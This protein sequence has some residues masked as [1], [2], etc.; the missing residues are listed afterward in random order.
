MPSSNRQPPT[1]QPPTH[2]RGRSRQQQ[3]AHQVEELTHQAGEKN[4]RWFVLG[5]IIT[6]GGGWLFWRLLPPQ[7]QGRDVRVSGG[8]L[9]SV[10]GGGTPITPPQV[11]DLGGRPQPG[12]AHGETC[13]RRRR[14]STHQRL[15]IGSYVNKRPDRTQACPRPT[16]GRRPCHLSAPWSPANFDVLRPL[17]LDTPLPSPVWFRPSGRPISGGIQG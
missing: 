5:V 6:L 2:R 13:R 12:N 16:A 15:I 4:R 10:R 3:Q 14:R 17:P 9:H 1:R 11:A 7:P 8:T